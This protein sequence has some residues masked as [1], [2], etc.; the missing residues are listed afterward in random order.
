MGD[1]VSGQAL[2]I[3][4]LEPVPIPDLD[5]VCPTFWQLAQEL[6]EISHEVAPVLVV[7]RPEP[8]KLKHEE[9]DIR[10]DGFARVQER[11]REQAG[12]EKV[13][14]RFACQVTEAIQVRDL[15][16]RDGVGLWKGARTRGTNTTL[17]SMKHFGQVWL[18]KGF[19]QALAVLV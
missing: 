5:A 14:V 6:V 17:N 13:L 3:L 9:A 4:R 19:A 18:S 2:E 10:A 11:L 15:L 16:D 12:V 8:R 1:L 7:G